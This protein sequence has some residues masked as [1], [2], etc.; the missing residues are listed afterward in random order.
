MLSSSDDADDIRQAYVLGAS[1]YLIKPA[2]L[3]GLKTLLRKIH[4]YWGECE[5]PE[6][7]AEGYAVPTSSTGRLGARYQKPTR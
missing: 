1:S 6:V 5:V 2:T 7:D 3:A 4:D